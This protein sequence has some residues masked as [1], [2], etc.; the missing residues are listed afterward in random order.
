[1]QPT[2]SSNSQAALSLP[3]LTF[4]LGYKFIVNVVSVI[5]TTRSVMLFFFFI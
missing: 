4:E 1:M 3:N 5:T 2:W